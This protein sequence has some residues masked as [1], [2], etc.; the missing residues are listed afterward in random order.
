[1]ANQYNIIV[2]DHEVKRIVKMLEKHLVTVRTSKFDA[3]NSIIKVICF[4]SQT[5][6]IKNELK[7]MGI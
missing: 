4:E 3:V 7:E 5:P 6:L 1:M 2:T